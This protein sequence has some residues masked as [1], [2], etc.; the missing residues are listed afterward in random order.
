MATHDRLKKTQNEMILEH[1]QESEIGI[2]PIDALNLYG[3]FRL[4]ARISDLRREGYPIVSERETRN[5]KTYCRYRL[6]D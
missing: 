5:G 2:T 1:L 6:E 3:C 4:S